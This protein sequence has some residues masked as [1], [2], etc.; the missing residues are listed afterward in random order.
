VP[1]ALREIRNLIQAAAAASCQFVLARR[2]AC[3]RHVAARS[4]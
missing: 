2:L 3:G 4:L 1:V